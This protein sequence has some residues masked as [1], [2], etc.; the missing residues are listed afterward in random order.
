MGGY[1][2]RWF[3]VLGAI[4]VVWATVAQ[5]DASPRPSTGLIS[6]VLPGTA[7][8]GEIVKVRG[9]VSRAP[10]GST[11]ELERGGTAGRWTVLG[12][13]AV[14]KGRFTVSWKPVA[15]G[16]VTVRLVVVRRGR[17]VARTRTGK[18]LIGAAPVLCAPPG[19]PDS[20]PQ[21]DGSVVG[22]VYNVGG[23]APG[24]TVCHGQAERVT[25]ADTSGAVVAAEDVAGGQSYRFDLPPGL[26]TLSAG[27]C[28]GSATVRA[29]AE[30]HAD[31]TCDV[32]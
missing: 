18:L 3:A 28:R 12:K 7:T 26:Y 13:G 22:G 19:P 31:T 20:L 10:G 4:A 25:A 2:R 15:S 5:V 9:R 23:V 17:T 32:P 6:A 1:R 16:F 29:G 27:A 30:T 21:G 14:S 8:V 11:A 24:V